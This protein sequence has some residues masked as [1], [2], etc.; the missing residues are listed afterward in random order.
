MPRLRPPA[1]LTSP[2]FLDQASLI[3]DNGVYY[4]GPPLIIFAIVLVSLCVYVYFAVFY[5][6]MFPSMWTLG[7]ILNMIVSM[8]L[9][10]QIAFN[11]FSC[12]LVSPGHP[13]Q[14]TE[15]QSLGP[16][17]KLCSKCAYIAHHA[18]LR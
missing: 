10:V 7:G 8:W 11:Y 12:I 6:T 5:P 2:R 14:P 9:V 3:I 15:G 4:L 18:C 16:G 17:V 13:P 1:F